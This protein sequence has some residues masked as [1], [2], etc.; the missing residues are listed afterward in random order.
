MRT[1][2]P[3]DGRLWIPFVRQSS[4]TIEKLAGGQVFRVRKGDKIVDDTL[5]DFDEAVDLVDDMLRSI[6]NLK[7]R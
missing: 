6:N 7:G 5:A 4:M 1:T 3:S 2:T